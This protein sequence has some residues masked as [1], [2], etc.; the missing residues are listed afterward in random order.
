[1][2]ITIIEI[3]NKSIVHSRNN[4]TLLHKEKIGRYEGL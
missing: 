3:S 4:R 2:T 1:M